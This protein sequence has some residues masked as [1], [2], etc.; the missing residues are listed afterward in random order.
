MS[1]NVASLLVEREGYVRRGLAN[2]V[3]QVDEQLARLGFAVESEAEPE[4][5]VATKRRTRK[6]A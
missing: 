3:A 4:V 2:R 6:P 5:E 1:Q